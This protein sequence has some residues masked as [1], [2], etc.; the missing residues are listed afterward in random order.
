LDTKTSNVLRPENMTRRKGLR[1]VSFLTG[2][3]TLI[4]VIL[5]YTS[6]QF[7]I[8]ILRLTGLQLL[9]YNI[10]LGDLFITIP[11]GMRVFIILSM[12][13]AAAGL[14]LLFLRKNILAS[15][16]FGGAAIAALIE[17]TYVS[18]VT[19][20]ASRA[21]VSNVEGGMLS[22]WTAF[23]MLALISALLALFET[24]LEKSAE[25]IFKVSASIS[26]GAVALITIYMFA[27]GSPAI[28]EIGLGDFL[29]GTAWKPTADDPQFGILYM[30]LASLFGCLG[31][32]AIGVPIGLLTA[33][34]L[35]EIAPSWLRSVVR[36]SVELLAGIPSVIYGFWGMKVLVPF[37][38]TNFTK[39]GFSSTGSGLMAVILILSIMILPTII[40][41][42]E[43][44]LR[45]VP[46][47]YT[48][49]SL[50]LGNTKIS[51]IFAVQIPAARSGIL[52]G[53]ILGVGR[54]I[55]ETM[56]VIMVAGNIVQLPT[57]F[58]SVRPMTAGIAF[59]MGY[60]E[61]GLHRQALFGIGLVLF[62]FIMLVNITFTYIS[63]R[64]VQMDAK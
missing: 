27:Y 31:A 35:A 13:A 33:V 12:A 17:I 61:N 63:K 45:S 18:S 56:A 41:V 57:L 42:A 48:E 34:F 53:V 7:D 20:A 58:S 25:M 32:I 30:I 46:P 64:G 4:S 59:E 54:A 19:Q 14:V 5:P 22:G 8:Y 2:C 10:R 29:F 55:G 23:F 3:L 62:V 50:A 43:T 15:T 38:R 60:A 1:L 36:P 11:T 51:T 6:F 44:A 24:G 9:A 21:G 16:A 37:L 40:S 39:L 47:S 49:A 28:I 26:V 52:A